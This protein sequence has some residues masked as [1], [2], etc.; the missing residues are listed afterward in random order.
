MLIEKT[1]L[2]VHLE[3]MQRVGNGQGTFG[4]V[5]VCVC[6]CVCVVRQAPTLTLVAMS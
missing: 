1:H 3:T 4:W 6:V 5:C 2:V